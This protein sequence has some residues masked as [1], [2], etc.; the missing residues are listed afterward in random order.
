MLDDF[1][2]EMVAERAHTHLNEIIRTILTAYQQ[3]AS[4]LA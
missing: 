1:N 3:Y 4:T 2:A